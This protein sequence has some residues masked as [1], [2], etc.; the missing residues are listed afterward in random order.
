MRVRADHVPALAAGRPDGRDALLLVVRGEL[1]HRR[2]RPTIPV[3]RIESGRSLSSRPPVRR[4]ITFDGDDWERIEM[5]ARESGA[6]PDEFVA[7]VAARVERSAEGD[8][9]LARRG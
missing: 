8:L 2:A 9:V 7:R 3:P 6:S 5:L 1:G 4:T